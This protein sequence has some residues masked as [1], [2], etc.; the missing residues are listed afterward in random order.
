MNIVLVLITVTPTME[1]E[2][3][4]QIKKFKQVTE[5]HLLY[6]PY[7][8]YVRAEAPTTAELERLVLDKL[9]G[10]KGIKSTMTCFIAD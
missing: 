10:I 3:L 7:D 5:A 2:V 1:V 9:R 8:I 4:E 6:G